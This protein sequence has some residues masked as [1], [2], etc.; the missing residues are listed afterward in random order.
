MGYVY[1]VFIDW[2][3]DGLP[4]LICP[5]ET[6]RI[7]WYKN[8]GTRQKPIFG[9]RRQILCDGYPDSA[10]LRT[11]SARRASSA[12]SNNGVY[13][14]EKERPFM[15]RTGVA[16]AD[17]NGDK[18][19]DFV[20][21]D[22]HTRKAT[23]FTQ[24]RNRKGLLRLRK[25]RVLKLADGR[26]IDDRIVK[27][28]SHWTESF[29]SVDWDRDGLVDLVYSFAGAQGGIQ[30]DGSIYL[31]RNC[32]TKTDPIFESPVTM[33]CFGEAIR[34]TNHGPHPW[35]GDFNGDGTPDLLCCVEWSVYPFYTHAALMMKQRP[36]YELGQ[37]W[38]HEP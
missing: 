24:Y 15:W 3:A 12:D 34:V 19:T 14:T 5:N 26:V 38:K 1:P 29:R 7:F 11:L 28:R 33:R 8:R 25:N 2:D 22:G 36:K 20:T 18:L 16:F 35:V 10:Q 9:K 17:F 21:L 4:D 30:D 13:P 6:N 31:L 23:L 37:V 32:G 27:R